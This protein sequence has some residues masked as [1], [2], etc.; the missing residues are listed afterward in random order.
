VSERKMEVVPGRE[1]AFSSTME[2]TWEGLT[3]RSMLKLLAILASSG[4]STLAITS[5][6]P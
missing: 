4:S 3:M 2:A 6:T 1:M 5:G